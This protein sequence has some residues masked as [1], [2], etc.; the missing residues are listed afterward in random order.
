MICRFAATA[1]LALV[2]LY[3]I[4]VTSL[5]LFQRQL[6]YDPSRNAPSPAE[7]GFDGATEH[8]LSAADGTRILLWHAPADPGAATILYFQGKGGEIADRPNRWAAY[9][10]A[11]L[12]VAFPGYRGFGGS[13][14]SPTEAGLHQD[15]D[16]AL[17]W[18][19]S[20]GIPASQIDIVGESLGTGV[21]SRL[22]ADRQTGALI[23]EAP[24]TSLAD[25][26]AGRFP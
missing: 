3:L 23:L 8:V 21:A 11:G 22:A 25:V 9:R 12:G 6:I 20:Q 13:D 26:A 10:A 1:F 7:A 2:G 16:A 5:F 24:Y 4:G 17:D 14:G 19:L 18:L 15:A